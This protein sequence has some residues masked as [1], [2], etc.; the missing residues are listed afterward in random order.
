MRGSWRTP[1]VVLTCGTI[2]LFISFGARNIFGLLLDPMTES[3]ALDVG[4]FSLAIGIQAVIWG[5]TTPITASIA[6]R[7]GT[8]RMIALGGALYAVGLALMAMV[9]TPVH[10]HLTAGLMLGLGLSATGS[11]LFWR[12][13]QNA[14][15][16]SAVAC[17]SE[18]AAPRALRAS[19]PWCRWAST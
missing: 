5:L 1:A 17:S 2:I 14:W 15:M 12:P 18:L 11:R 8:A 9:Q 4:D 10:M 7:Y 13:L 16:P 3:T 6:E 19:S